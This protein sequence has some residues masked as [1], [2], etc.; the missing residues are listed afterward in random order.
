MH[1]W[2]KNAD[3]N[4]LNF[5]ALI[6]QFFGVCLTVSIAVITSLTSHKGDRWHSNKI[7]W[8]DKDQKEFKIKIFWRV[9]FILRIFFTSKITLLNT[10]DLRWLQRLTVKKLVYWQ[11]E[12]PHNRWHQIYIGTLQTTQTNKQTNKKHNHK[13][14]QTENKFN[15]SDWSKLAYQRQWTNAMINQFITFEW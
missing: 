10:I 12:A 3:A 9:R 4:I 13:T 14:N 2:L 5:E 7:L 8:P 6:A 1:S 15:L 11:E